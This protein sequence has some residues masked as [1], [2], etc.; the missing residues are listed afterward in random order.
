MQAHNDFVYFC[1]LLL[2]LLFP[3]L[4]AGQTH[5][6]AVR[7][8]FVPRE[9]VVFAEDFSGDEV[10]TNPSNWWWLAR[11]AADSAPQNK[12]WVVEPSEGGKCL[13]IK[14]EFFY[15]YPKVNLSAYMQDSFTLSCELKMANRYAE[16]AIMFRRKNDNFDL[17][18]WVRHLFSTYLISRRGALH[19]H[20]GVNV[21][22]MPNSELKT[23]IIIDHPVLFD[24]T[25]WH[26]MGVSYHKGNLK[27]YL[28]S[29]LMLNEPNYR[30]SI[31]TI[32]FG[33]R[34]TV[35]YRN[36]KVATGPQAQ[37][38][39]QLL[40]GRTLSTHAILF[41]VASTTIK[42]GSFAF[43]NELVDVLQSRRSLK[44]EI[45]GHTDG[46]GSDADNLALS[47]RRAGAVRDYLVSRG[48]EAK[49]LSIKGY[50]ES[51]PIRRGNSEQDKATNRRVDF[52]PR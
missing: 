37:P 52:V 22:E 17:R 48:V 50:G 10:G 38:V 3:V 18:P 23:R 5:R 40:R 1:P 7:E 25:A 28:D 32:L 49:R 16:S 26:H 43:L 13:A 4:L 51:K 30:Y 20:I 2:C 39:R 11:E 14:T 44:L 35:R 6:T 8:Q 15:F 36:V 21:D 12:T 45:C 29:F 33:G 41:D 31:D 19:S 24:T 34:T 9:V 47:E 46:D 27:I 42:P